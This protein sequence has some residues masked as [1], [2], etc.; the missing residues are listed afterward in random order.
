MYVGLIGTFKNLWDI[1]I[2]KQCVGV[3]IVFV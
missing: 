3:F 2:N 1:I